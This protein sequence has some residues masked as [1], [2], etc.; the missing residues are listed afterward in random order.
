MNSHKKKGAAA[1]I[2]AALIALTLGAA[3]AFTACPNSA[4]GGGSTV[5]ITV[6]GD[7]HI[8]LPSE[9]VAVRAGATWAEAKSTVQSKVSAQTDFL[10]DTWHLGADESA[11]ELKDTDTFFTHATV[12]V[13]SRPDLPDISSIQGSGPQVK[14]TFD[15]TPKEG[16]AI[17]GQ[18]P[19]SVNKGTCWNSVLKAYAEAALKVH[20]GFQCKGWQKKR[21]PGE[22]YLHLR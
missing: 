9:P 7:G 18:N 15:V 5:N 16:G 21:Q 14:I 19:I 6:R 10:I 12:F 20:Y 4:G 22:R 2:T 17:L 11:P 1:L 13:K 8:N 3:L